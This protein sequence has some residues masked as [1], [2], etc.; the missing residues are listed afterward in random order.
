[1]K[2][3]TKL[4][5]TDVTKG[6]AKSGK[7]DYVATFSTLYASPALGNKEINDNK[8]TQKF[9]SFMNSVMSSKG[10]VAK[11]QA[12]SLQALKAKASAPEATDKDVMTYRN[13]QSAVN[14]YRRQSGLTK[15][16]VAD[17]YAS[18]HGRKA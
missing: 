9:G 3:N 13:A 8:A 7:N 10:G 14:Y 12:V 4:F 5:G 2:N 15:S 17:A 1:V 16:N 18:I 11:S 6:E